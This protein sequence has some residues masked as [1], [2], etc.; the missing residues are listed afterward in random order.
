MAEKTDHPLE[1]EAASRKRL[2]QAIGLILRMSE[3]GAK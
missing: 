1:T 2:I 3:G